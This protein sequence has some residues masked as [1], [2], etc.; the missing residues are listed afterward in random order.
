M[1]TTAGALDSNLLKFSSGA[2][3]VGTGGFVDTSNQR[4][5]I[6]HVLPTKDLRRRS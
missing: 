6:Q 5:P 2:S 3:V 4:L 1:E